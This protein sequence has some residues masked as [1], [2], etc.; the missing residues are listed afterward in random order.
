MRSI[1]I[2]DRDGVYGMVRAHV[3][4]K[5]LGVHL[6][7]GAQMTVARAERAARA[8]AGHAARS[9]SITTSTSVAARAGAPTPTTSTPACPSPAGAAAPSARSR[10]RRSSR[11]MPRRR[12]RRDAR[13]SRARRSSCCSRPIARAGRTSCASL[14]AGR[15]R[16]D[17]GESLVGWREV[18]E[19]AAG[20][21]S[22]CG[23]ARAACSPTS[24]SHRRD[25]DR[26]SARR[27]RRSPLRDRSRA[28]A[29]PTTSRAR[30]ACAPAP[31]PPAIPLV[32]ATEVLYHSRARRPL[33]DVL[34]CIRHGVTL[35]T[36]GRLIRGNDEHDLRAPHAFA[37]ALRRRARRDRAHARDRR[38]LHVL[39][40]RA[41][42]SLSVRAPARRHDVR[43]ATC[44]SSTLRRRRVAL[45]RR[46]PGRTSARQLDAELALIEELDYPRLLPDDV[47]DRRRSAGGATSCARAAAPPPTRPSASAS[48]SP[49][50]I[51]S[52]WACCSSAS[53]RA[54]APSRPTSISTSSTSAAKKSSSTSTRVYGRDHAA[55]VCNIIRYRPRSAV[56]DVGKALGIPETALDRA[57][58]HLSMYGAVEPEA[59]ARAGPRDRGTRAALD[60]LAR[61][62]DEILEF[63][64]HLS[65]HPGGFLLGHEPVH[66]IVPIENA[67]MPGRTVIQWD[68]DDL[69]DLGAVQGRPARPRRAP[70]APPRASI[71]CAQHRGIDLVD[72]DDP[73]RGRRRPTT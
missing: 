60:H 13:R 48:A 72:G 59:L 11:S 71:C 37:R 36:A 19:R 22:R 17:K 21:R 9:A 70:P 35:A 51:R 24:S 33:Q 10:A 67:A 63:P 38:A 41:A 64:R 27:V 62:S 18:C 14:T 4:A 52:A 2:T 69:E 49:R 31:P 66:D 54:S 6:V 45:R 46:H 57:A 23:A 65:I 12:E 26:R 34:T 3:K 25:A 55:M 16:C 28:I 15:R 68:K 61:L 8:V 43:R 32:A 58:K 73:R 50:S 56:R 20:P 53:C 47:R 1:A 30:P 39:A 7:C 5:E 44:A 40:R 42:L 29:A